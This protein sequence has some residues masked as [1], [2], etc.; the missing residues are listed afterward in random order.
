MDNTNNFKN[1]A[2]TVDIL[3]FSIQNNELNIVLVK[4]D[5]E[6]YKNAWALPGGFVRIDES[7]DGAVK[8]VLEDKAGISDMYVEQL[9]TFGEVSRDPRSRVVTVSY[10]ALVP[11]HK[12]E[13]NKDSGDVKLFSVNKLS[14]LA[15]D[16]KKIIEYGVERLKAK[17]GYSNIA[18]GLLPKH[19]RLSD[20]QKVYE[21]ILSQKVDKRNFRKKML[22]LGLLKSTGKK[23]LEGA[24]RPAMLYEFKNKE[25]VFFD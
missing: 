12:L 4:R 21:I 9:F 6:P 16:H 22:S 7:L 17:I 1:P 5:T 13:I 19:F 15:F 8:R 20:L 2:L 14:N 11:N 23:E 24:H 25:V 18:F 10:F 3:I